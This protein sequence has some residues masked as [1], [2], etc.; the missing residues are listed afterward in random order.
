[1]NKAMSRF[2]P[3]FGQLRGYRKADLRGDLSAGLTVAVLL[4]PQG[5][6]YA[7]LAGMPPIYGLYAGIVP[8]VLYG[9]FG[10]TR[11]MSVGPVALLSLILLRG[12]SAFAES[13]T[14][15]FISLVLAAGILAGTIQLIL[16]SLRLGF[17]VNF[18]SHPVISGFTS[19]AAVLII[20]SQMEHIL[21]VKLAG[22]SYIWEEIGALAQALPGAKWQTLLLAL[23]SIAVM[24]ALRRWWPRFPG[25]LAVVGVSILLS[26][27]F[28]FDAAGLAL[29]GEVPSGLPGFRLPAIGATRW[30]DLFPLA[31][32]VCLISF[33]ES[34]AIAKALEGKQGGERV[35]PNQELLALGMAKLG[36]AFFQA[37]PT[38][39]SFT[40]SFVN[41]EAGARSGLA[42]IF[43]A[44]IIILILVFLTPVVQFLPNAVLGAVIIVSVMS[45]IEFR[46]AKRLWRN[47][48]WDFITLIVTF[49]ATLVLGILN[50][51][52]FGVILSL[53]LIIYQNS[54]PNYAVLGRLP[55]SN[56]YRSTARFHEALE[57]KGVL[58]VR[59]DAHLYFGNAAYFRS[60]IERL[61]EEREPLKLFVLDASGIH[62]VDSTGVE[63][64][65]DVMDWLRMRRIRFYV[66]GAIG[67]V[68][69]VLFR[70]DL[71]EEIGLK[72]Q[73]LKIQDA[74]DFFRE[75]GGF[76]PGGEALQS[77]LR[78]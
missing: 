60:T 66:S 48:R 39:G 43:S 56:V 20:I 75:E 74:I 13:G 2:F 24:L 62:D 9:L 5:M 59:F 26:W 61:V 33:I 58:I 22:S 35:R 19:A 29:V 8:A 30:V 36:G 31:L 65:R 42:S 7:L 3:L 67:P 27:A 4:V 46:Y 10:S 55:G 70:N 51:V 23:G 6:A 28:R 21:S 68:R 1:M 44:L 15:E 11:Q 57:E 73:F 37:F 77:N 69:D 53:A 64:L 52:M 76:S 41:Y 38:T 54:R 49:I 14:P 16:G 18:L 32:T 50:G 63:A 12:A 34:L 72:N 40:R 45:L 25:A 71:M 47:D 78:K 17:L